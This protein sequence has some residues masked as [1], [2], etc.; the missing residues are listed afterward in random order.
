MLLRLRNIATYLFHLCKIVAKLLHHKIHPDST[1]NISTLP[2]LPSG[3]LFPPCF[4]L[5]LSTTDSTRVQ[6]G[7][8]SL[9]LSDSLI[10]TM[11]NPSLNCT[12]FKSVDK[13]LG[14]QGIP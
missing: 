10:P 4:T 1:G 11:A 12:V 13:D 9:W 8:G 2:M 14:H 6:L 5:V 3:L 7:L